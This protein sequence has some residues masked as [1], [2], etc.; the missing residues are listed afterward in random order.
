MLAMFRSVHRTLLSDGIQHTRSWPPLLA[1]GLYA[2]FLALLCLR[3]SP[4]VTGDGAEYILLAERFAQG[5][6][7]HVPIA[8]ARARGLFEPRLIDRGGAQQL[9]HF[10]FLSLLAAP[11]VHVVG[12][13]PT[14][15]FAIVNVGL[16]G[17]AFF[18][19][20]RRVGPAAALFVGC[21]PIL[22]WVDKAQVEVFTVAMTAIGCALIARPHLAAAAF[23][24]AATQNPPF[25]VVS[26][27][28]CIAAAFGSIGR[29]VCADRS[30]ACWRCSCAPCI[31]CSI[32]GGWGDGRR[33]STRRMC[34]F[35]GCA[36]CSPSS[37][38]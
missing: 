7:P 22:W 35:P 23:G 16:L 24:F 15:A 28:L 37:P 18:I 10:W 5:Q 36:R 27:A 2:A 25:A 29:S 19:V 34:G 26:V 14:A 17:L 33:S 21:S 32:C 31:R 11:L 8:E 30:G 9:W 13:V 38:T 1:T 4:L 3:S 20:H 12:N 6:L